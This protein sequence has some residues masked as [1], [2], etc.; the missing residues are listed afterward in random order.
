M[1]YKMVAVLILLMLAVSTKATNFRENQQDKISG[2]IRDLSCF[3]WK[4]NIG[5]LAS[6]IINPIGIKAFESSIT[7]GWTLFTGD[8]QMCLDHAVAYTATIMNNFKMKTFEANY[9]WSITL[10]ICREGK[11]EYISTVDDVKRIIKDKPEFIKDNNY[12][13]NLYKEIKEDLDQGRNRETVLLYHFSD[14][15]FLLD[16]KVGSNNDCSG[17][18]CCNEDAGIP[19]S[20]DKEAGKWGDYNCDSNP[21]SFALLKEAINKTGIPDLIVWTGDSNN[22]GI[23]FTADDTLNSTFILTKELN[24][25]FPNSAIFPIHGNHEFAPMNSQNFSEPDFIARKLSETWSEWLTPEVEKEL[26]EKSFYS[27]ESSTHPKST[28]DFKTKIGKTRLIALNTQNCYTW[29]FFLI[30]EMNDPGQE[31]DWLESQLKEMEKN[32]EVAIIFGHIP[33]GESDWTSTISLRMRALYDRYQHVIRLNLFGHTHIEEFSVI[34]SI[35]DKKPIGVIHISPSFTPHINVNPSFR[36]VTLDSKTKLP[37]KIETYRM[38]LEKANRNDTYAKF[39]LLHEFAQEYNLTDLSPAS[40]LQ[41]ASKINDD[42]STAIQYKANKHARG[43][44]TDQILASKW[45]ESC[46]RIEFCHVSNSVWSDTRDCVK[47][48]D[49][50]FFD[51]LSYLTDFMFGV[52]VNKS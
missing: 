31:F 52:W 49:F 21:A 8:Y 20:K 38:D 2:I 47:L 28:Q 39:D 4:T 40:A 10:P 51:Y 24:N 41:L 44:G 19:T 48:S 17:L 34:R 43:K 35:E 30:G 13:N 9:F 32:G 50:D 42:E 1:K 15:H 27:Y 45:D 7:M 3:T 23:Q 18:V 25:M 33:P 46:R 37:L 22:H 6:L 29:N 14:F 5:T 36:V 11:Y 16:Y 26:R 12:I